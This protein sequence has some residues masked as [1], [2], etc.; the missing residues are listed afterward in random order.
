MLAAEGTAQNDQRG[1][2][3]HV[4]CSIR[5]LTVCPSDNHANGAPD[6]HVTNIVP[7][8]AVSRFR[9][10]LD[11]LFAMPFRH[12]SL[13]LLNEMDGGAARRLLTNV[14]AARLFQNLLTG[15]R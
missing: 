15:Q 10:G 6:Q 7:D 2:C 5:L 13:V 11:D 4:S 8:H 9:R 14:V 1:Q 12:R 3:V